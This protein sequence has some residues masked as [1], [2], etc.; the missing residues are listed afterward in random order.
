M[1]TDRHGVKGAGP[2]AWR[3]HL[4]PATLTGWAAPSPSGLSSSLLHPSPSFHS[5]REGALYL[6]APN[7][8]RRLATTHSA[9]LFQE[10]LEARFT[11]TC[12]GLEDRNLRAVRV[13]VGRWMETGEDMMLLKEQRGASFAQGPFRFFKRTFGF[14][15]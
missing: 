6:C 3:T 15:A 13:G 1:E 11:Q 14:L 2:N 12:P 4:S 8:A 5:R 7:S 10:G 9:G